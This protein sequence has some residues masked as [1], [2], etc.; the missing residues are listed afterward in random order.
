MQSYTTLLVMLICFS[1]C[2]IL[3][4]LSRLQNSTAGPQLRSS[5]CSV[6]ARACMRGNHCVFKVLCHR[7]FCGLSHT[8]CW[9]L[10]DWP[11][12]VEKE[13][14]VLMR[15]NTQGQLACC[16]EGSAFQRP[17]RLA[18]LYV[19]KKSLWHWGYRLCENITAYTRFLQAL[20][21]FT[22]QTEP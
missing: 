5:Q 2:Y 16:R 12:A 14:Q 13:F 4:R 8:A 22:C 6:P 11:Q 3:L 1:F 20:K 15:W 18:I 9:D 19:K 21:I 7:S 10:L 17:C